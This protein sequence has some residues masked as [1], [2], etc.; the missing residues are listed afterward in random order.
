V[1]LQGLYLYYSA[2]LCELFPGGSYP[3]ESGYFTFT[4]MAA[5]DLPDCRGDFHGSITGN[6]ADRRPALLFHRELK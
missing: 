5:V 3:W 4:D 6:L 1:V 2:G